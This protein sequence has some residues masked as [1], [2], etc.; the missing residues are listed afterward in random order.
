MPITY[1]QGPSGHGALGSAP[2]GREYGF[3]RIQIH[4]RTT[5]TSI[6]SYWNCTVVCLVAWGLMFQ[7][8]KNPPP[9]PVSWHGQDDEDYS[10]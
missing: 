3:E 8:A 5:S 10:R 1:A 4:E 6:A 2:G 7:N 9:M